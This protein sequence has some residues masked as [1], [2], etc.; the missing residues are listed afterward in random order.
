V[1]AQA[2][3]AKVLVPLP[4]AASVLS[5]YGA[6]TSDVV[7]VVQRWRVLKL[8]VPGATVE[9]IFAALES[10]AS[11]K[12]ADQGIETADI[13]LE[14]SARMRFSMQIHDVEVPV[15]AGRLD[16]GAVQRIDQRF[17]EV[18]D[19]LFGRGSGDRTGGIDFT[20]FQV[21][22]TAKTGRADLTSDE[23]LEA[24]RRSRAVYWPELRDFRDTPVYD[25]V[26]SAAVEGPALI[27]L[28]DTVI[29]IRPGQRGEPDRGGNYVIDLSRGAR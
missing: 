11:E 23:R 4:H 15:P 6:A 20:A 1:A 10:E 17:E 5:A 19:Q 16:D 29:A 28:P 13:T 24:S 26:P 21:R 3:I 12:F 9:E 18:H 14:R 25:E 22:A 8:P 7:H 27:E 2:A